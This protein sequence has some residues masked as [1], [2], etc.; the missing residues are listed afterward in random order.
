MTILVITAI[1]IGMIILTCL[2]L[3]D[4]VILAAIASL[5]TGQSSARDKIVVAMF[6][7]FE[8]AMVIGVGVGAWGL[9]V[10]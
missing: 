1:I 2:G 10:I 6:V 9:T 3:I 7:A 4:F 8:A 5:A